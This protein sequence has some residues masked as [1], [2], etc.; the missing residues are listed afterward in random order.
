MKSHLQHWLKGTK[1]DISSWEYFPNLW[2]VKNEELET[3]QIVERGEFSETYTQG[4]RDLLVQIRCQALKDT[5]PTPLSIT[6]MLS[7]KALNPQFLYEC[8]SVAYF[9]CRPNNLEKQQ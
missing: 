6:F 7:S 2:G 8:C 5:D 3:A 9:L 1:I 4:M